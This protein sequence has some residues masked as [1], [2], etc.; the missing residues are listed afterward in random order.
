MVCADGLSARRLFKLF[1]KTDTG[2]KKKK[3]AEEISFGDFVRLM[4]YM[5][6]DNLEVNLILLNEAEKPQ[7]ILDKEVPDNLNMIDFGCYSDLCDALGE[8]DHIKAMQKMCE[9]LYP[10][11]KQ[12]DFDEVS[13]F[14]IWGFCNW[15]AT[16]VDRINKIF[17]SVNIEYTEQEKKAGIDK[18]QFGTFG[19][20]DWYARR[21][22]ITDQNQVNKEK[23]VRIYQCMKNDA[24]ETAYSRRLQ[25]VYEQDAKSHRH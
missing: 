16:E 13:V 23:W 6:Q 14:D 22:G 3:D 20:L 19:I 4:P 24:E 18:L 9:V 25:K 10:D 17:S 12:K 11:H 21:M 7:F 8:E 1:K 5:E 2:M 15:V